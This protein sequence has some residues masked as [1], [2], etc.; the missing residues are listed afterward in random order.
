MAGEQGECRPKIKTWIL[1]MLH[2]IVTLLHGG[3]R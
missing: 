1:E 2:R 3:E